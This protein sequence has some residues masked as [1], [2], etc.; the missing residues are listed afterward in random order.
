MIWL[1]CL[2][3]KQNILE[4]EHLVVLEYM[5]SKYQPGTLHAEHAE[6]EHFELVVSYPWYDSCDRIG[7]PL[8][9]LQS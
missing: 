9:H 4:M 3:S 1:I 8:L 2:S 6:G 5:L 7:P